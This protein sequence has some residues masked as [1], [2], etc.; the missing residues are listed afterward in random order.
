MIYRLARPADLVFRTVIYEKGTQEFFSMV[1]VQLVLE[2]V[3]CMVI[4]QYRMIYY[5][6]C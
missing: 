6:A 3:Y 2:V 5:L 4:L 1:Y